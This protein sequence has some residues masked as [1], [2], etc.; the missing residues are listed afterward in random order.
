M[1]QRNHLLW[2]A[3]KNLG[4]VYTMCW[5]LPV[6][7]PTDRIQSSYMALPGHLT[8][9]LKLPF[10]II[11][12]FFYDDPSKCLPFAYEFIDN[13]Y[14]DIRFDIVVCRYIGPAAKLHLWKVAP[15]FV[16]IDDHP[17]EVYDTRDKY[18]VPVYKRFIAR[19]LR[20]CSL[21][22]VV[23]KMKGGWVANAFH[24]KNFNKENIFYLPNLPFLP[25]DKYGIA[26]RRENYLLFV[27]RMNYQPNYMGVDSFLK[28]IWPSVSAKFPLLQFRI[29]GA[30]A[31]DEYVEKWKAIANVEYMGFAENLEPVYEKCLAAVVPIEQGSGTCI[32]TLES[33]AYSRLCL[34]T[35]FGARGLDK[36]EK[37]KTNGVLIFHNTQEFIDLLS[38]VIMNEEVRT[39][40]ELEA[41]DYLYA[42]YG[43]GRF[44]G[45]V[46]ECI[47]TRD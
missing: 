21:Y 29:V 4:E 40:M 14:K 27:G 3:L 32:K 37:D 38:D 26:S 8:R 20:M 24:I 28:N 35:P 19:C 12:N 22:L 42:N 33:L 16:D 10:E 23:K 18:K 31:P 45:A 13:P 34:S 11:W 43:I 46:T 25:S 30:K 47:V 17:I 41:H 5:K 36:N 15:L 7:N 6:E 44:E 9:F 39:D 2:N 1:E